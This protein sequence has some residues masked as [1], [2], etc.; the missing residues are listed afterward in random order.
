MFFPP[1]FS[2]YYAIRWYIRYRRDEATH[3]RRTG[4]KGANGAPQTGAPLSKAKDE[5][6][7]LQE[8]KDELNRSAL[9]AKKTDGVSK[10]NPDYFNECFI[11]SFTRR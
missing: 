3:R 7:L 1:N 6:E 10:K 4:N 11:E 8:L 5:K 9:G 2:V